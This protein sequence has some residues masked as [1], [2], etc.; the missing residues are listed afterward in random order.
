VVPG[1]P[2]ADVTVLGSELLAELVPG[3]ATLPAR[4]DQ[5]WRWPLP[6]PVP[7]RRCCSPRRLIFVPHSLNIQRGVSSHGL[8]GVQEVP[9]AGFLRN[10]LTVR[11][12]KGD[13][14]FVVFRVA[15]WRRDVESAVEQ[16]RNRD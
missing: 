4:R 8:A 14:R 12:S 2:G 1:E 13:E 15:A 3:G 5:Q 10:E 6:P 11:Y 16:F 9:T 7:A